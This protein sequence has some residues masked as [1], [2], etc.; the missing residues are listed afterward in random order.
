M[1]AAPFSVTG[2]TTAQLEL[3][4]FVPDPDQSLSLTVQANETA[5]NLNLSITWYQGVGTLIAEQ[6]DTSYNVS[7]TSN[8]D[9]YLMHTVQSSYSIPYTFKINGGPSFESGS[10]GGLVAGPLD[11]NQSWGLAVYIEQPYTSELPT[12]NYAD[13]L[14]FTIEAN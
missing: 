7:V 3:N 13:I 10:S 1:L 6:E 9:F 2:A 12:G 11:Y 5:S 8:N 4:G 14:T